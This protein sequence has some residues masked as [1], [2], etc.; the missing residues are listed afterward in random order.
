GM[1]TGFDQDG[2]R[3]LLSWLPW[4]PNR[5]RAGNYVD[6]MALLRVPVLRSMGGYTTDRRL[7]GWEDY[8]LY[9]RLAEGGHTGAFLPEIMARYRVSPTSMV[10]FSNMSVSTAF[11]ALKERCPNLMRNVLAPL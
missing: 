10:S 7:Y 5:L 2:H 1:L 8:E 4:D 6:A 9:C 3:H 11:T